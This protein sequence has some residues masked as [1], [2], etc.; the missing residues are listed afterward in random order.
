MKIKFWSFNHAVIKA[1]AVFCLVIMLL[2]SCK[3]K[4]KQKAA[5]P[6]PKVVVTQI[7]QQ[8]IPIIK[9]YSGTVTSIK[10]VNIVP[11]VSGYIM[12]RYFIEGTVV[13]KDAPLYLIDPRPY[14]AKLDAA[15]ARLKMDQASM[16]FWEKEKKRYKRLA[17]KGAASQEKAQGA[18]TNFMKTQAAIEKDK[19]DIENAE[20]ELSFTRINAPFTGRIMQ[21]KFH[22]GALVHRQ[23]DVLTTLVEMDP[24]YVIFNISRRD[25]FELQLLK[26][27]KKIFDVKDMRLQIEM[28]DNRIYAHEGKIDFIDYLINPTT[29]SVTVRGIFPNPHTEEAQG[30]YDLIPGQ[31]A[32]VHLIAGENPSAILIPKPALL[33]GEL[34]S[35]VLVVGRDNKV[36]S[37]NVKLG[38]VYE[39]QWI[40]TDG[41][42]PGEQI[43]IEGVQKV[44]DGMT[45]RPQ[46]A[47]SGSDA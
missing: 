3:P 25:V 11:R 19:A 28:P 6:A 22:K 30:D 41:L 24:I 13:E 43:V 26:R 47:P 44:K 39:K 32:P 4:E 33:Q 10:T 37:R 40:I 29:D 17:S 36:A 1:V 31:Y 27:E 23:R 45:V 35:R 38:G 46:M 9:D 8:K 2:P 14:K 18:M 7:S 34:G 20:L 12:E 42:K 16:K 5:P 21:T 15:L